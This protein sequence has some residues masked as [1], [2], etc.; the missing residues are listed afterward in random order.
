MSSTPLPPIG[1]VGAPP[2]PPP[3][4]T[5]PNVTFGPP[6]LRTQ[7]NAAVWAAVA[8][9]PASTF[10][11]LFDG[12]TLS[13]GCDQG[14]KT[15]TARAL[16]DREYDRHLDPRDSLSIG[17]NP[18]RADDT[19][20]AAWIDF[21]ALGLKPADRGA[22]MRKAA[23]LD[24]P[25]S[26][27]E[28]RSGS[29][30]G[31]FCFE[32]PTAPALARQIA[33][34]MGT[35]LGW[36]E[37]WVGASKQKGDRFFEVYPK[38]DTSHPTDCGSWIRLPFPG[39][40]EA[41]SRRGTWLGERRPTFPQWLAWAWQ[42]RVPLAWV[43]SFVVELPSSKV[44]HQLSTT[45][46]TASAT[47][48]ASVAAQAPAQ[49]ALDR[50]GSVS[51]DDVRGWVSQLAPDRAEGYDSWV[52]ILQAI[53]NQFAGTDDES[54]AIALLE[55]WSQTSG[56]YELGV[57]AKKWASFGKQPDKPQ[58]TIR[59]LMYAA[60]HDADSVAVAAINARYAFTYQNG[61]METPKVGEPRF[62]ETPRFREVLA[63]KT[64]ANG[65]G[66]A[67]R[68]A[69][70]WLQSPERREYY[71]CRFD[72]TRAPLTGIPSIERPGMRDFNLYP[73]LALAPSAAGSC[74]LF[75]DHIR[76]VICCG[77]AKLYAWVTMW[78]ADI[79]QH[80]AQLPGTA[81]VLKS[82][83]VGTGKTI[84]GEI[85]GE[86]LGPPLYVSI[87]DREKFLG[88]F[89]GHRARKLLL[90][91]EEAVWAGDRKAESVLKD[92]VT[93]NTTLVERKYVEAQQDIQ[94]ARL[95]MTTNHDWA[96][97]ATRDERRFAVLGVSPARRNDLS[98]FGALR[99]Q[100]FEDGGCARLLH[101]L[102]SE[103]TV[104]RDAIRRP[105]ATQAL[106]DQQLRSADVLDQ[107]LH[108]ALN[109]GFIALGSPTDTSG[110]TVRTEYVT[111]A[112]ETYARKF[113]NS[114]WTT[115]GTIVGKQL[116][117]RL[118]AAMSPAR[119]RINGVQ[120]RCYQFASL[121]DCRAAFATGLAASPAWDGPD[122]WAESD[123]AQGA[124]LGAV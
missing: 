38:Q 48:T 102:L 124:I 59:T 30:H 34:T 112:A 50:Q 41:T 99:R 95:L 12:R 97:P 80:P 111:A 91:I 66:K 43:E 9:D 15:W 75:L 114:A 73:G 23:E 116:T 35:A 33:R 117:R 45:A 63:N 61:I 86:I 103:V 14:E 52:E 81:L 104:D 26:F 94:C 49:L 88:P 44:A 5:L 54:D 10:R 36:R 115:A 74:D 90:Q 110:V 121:A 2:V 82:E 25:L 64:V 53:H 32:V 20:L 71:A 57:V 11:R 79:F 39:G 76:E 78:F 100:M 3:T 67:R 40:E 107:W 13:Y 105:P 120:V 51:L 37:M 72:P 47:A 29:L 28:S 123:E 87:A 8:S 17:I 65:R 89:A 16:T 109:T 68:L 31:I 19:V 101:H 6:G 27:A 18:V 93:N 60:Q 113:K 62:V 22:I 58:R 1:Q 118:G 108:D 69:D 122:T 7:I 21:D 24:Y 70:V 96:V 106:V 85:I 77:N 46:P 42:R 92:M 55:E 56:K 4:P 98:Y 83:E 119:P 84:V